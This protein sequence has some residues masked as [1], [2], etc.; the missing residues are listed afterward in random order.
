M[1][2]QGLFNILELYSER[3]DFFYDNVDKYFR[4]LLNNDF[5]NYSG[6]L[7]EL[8]IISEN[9]NKKVKTEIINLGFQKNKIE[10]KFSSNYLIITE[11]D[12]DE[13]NSIQTLYEKKIA[14]V[15]YEVFLEAILYYIADLDNDSLTL[16]LKSKGFL[17]I[18]F[19]LEIS[20]LKKLYLTSPDK[21]EKLQKYITIQDKIVEKFCNSKEKIETLEDITEV[22]EKLQLLFLIYRIL[23]FFQSIKFFNFSHLKA[24]IEQEQAE[25]LY[26]LPIVTLKTP[27]LYYCGIYLANKLGAQINKGKTIEF[28]NE[29]YEEF[30]DEFEAP[31]VEATDE[32]YY[33]LKS[34]EIMKHWLTIEKL[35][36]LIHFDETFYMPSYLQELETSQLVVI[37]KLFYLLKYQNKVEPSFIA[38]II[39]EIGERVS[40]EGIKHHRDGFISSESTYYVFFLNYMMNTLDKLKDYDFLDSIVTRIY[41]NLELINFSS[42][43]NHDL[44]SEIFYSIE[45]LK[46]FN[47]VETK[48]MITHLVKYLF[49]Q[50]IVEKVLKSEEITNS[51]VRF[52][53]LKVNKITGET[54]Y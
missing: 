9:L 52:R 3:K 38:N 23:G 16:N 4:K 36:P 42:E 47:C 18:E 45:T 21:L 31:L 22:Q 40:P 43:T 49:P 15:V 50:E 48:E 8:K 14:P 27:D 51:E 17:P 11:A 30:I 20:T 29:M 6:N 41:R 26:S 10:N 33:F 7:D 46:L 13:I 19:I 37:I 12:L 2:L 54:E 44:L 24:F 5:E 35:Y 25:W 1:I 28:F 32:L 53:H 34:T 39:E